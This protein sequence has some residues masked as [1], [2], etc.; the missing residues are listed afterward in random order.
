[1][2]LPGGGTTPNPN[3][4]PAAA[5]PTTP[6][7]PTTD[8]KVPDPTRT[9][10]TAPPPPATQNTVNQAFRDVLTHILTGPTPEQAGEGAATS[11]TANAYRT[12]TQ[13]SAE[14]QQRQA[15][16]LNAVQGGNANS[17]QLAMAGRGIEQQRGE[18][19]SNFVANLTES[20]IKDR[21]DELMQ[22]LNMA[23]ASGDA[24]AARQ[25]QLQIAEMNAA[26][27]R[28]GQEIT[29]TSVGNQFT[30]GQGDLDV[31]RTGLAN[32]L[33]LGQGDLDLRSKLGQGDLDLRNKLG[34]GDLDLRRYGIDVGAD[35][36]MKE[37]GLGYTQLGYQARRDA[38][39]DAFG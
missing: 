28:S 21:R 13:R 5:A 4:P 36:A 19:E 11:G 34:S 14:R 1:M 27:E 6:T 33:T 17:P 32:Q 35:T 16:H 23:M 38:L 22:G 29:R 9:D 2:S 12:A 3:A 20:K 18:D 26:L 15:A 39:A 30:L 8:P 37:L 25:I 24:D 10:P 31:R 7:T